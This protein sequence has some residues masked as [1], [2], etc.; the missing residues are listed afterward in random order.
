VKP[1]SDK[2]AT[3][4]LLA[5]EWLDHAASSFS[6]RTI[7]MTRIYIGKTIIPLHRIIRRALSHGVR[8]VN[9]NAAIDAPSPR[10]PLRQMAP[11]EPEAVVRLFRIAKETDPSPAAF[12]VLAAASGARRRRGNRA[13]LR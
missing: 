11:S 5:N 1:P 8:L 10:A 2:E 12:V 4:G 3:L 9:H 13:P 6:P 7:T